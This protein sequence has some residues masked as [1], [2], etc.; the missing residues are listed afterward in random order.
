MRVRNIGGIAAVA[1]VLTACAGSSDAA[2]GGTTAAPPPSPVETVTF[3][4]TITDDD[5]QQVT[6]E[7]PP[8][9]IVTF[10]PSMTETL[11]A[12]GLGDRLVG[13]SGPY[14]D[15]PAAAR[16]VA[17]IGGAGEFGVDP[18][19]EK[20]VSLQPDLF[21][22]ISGGDQWKQELR[23]LS[24]P[25]VTLNATDLPD[26]LEDIRV[27][28]DVT[29]ATEAS[30]AL[31]SDMQ[32][33]ADAVTASVDAAGGSVSCFFEVYFPPLTSIGPDTFIYDLLERAGCDPTTAG[34]KADY[35][36]WSVE[37]LI[38]GQPDV[39]LA[40]PESAKSTDAVASRPGFDAI[41][42]VSSGAVV[43]VD[44]DLITRPGPRVIDGLEALEAGLHPSG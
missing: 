18:N 11:F 16:Q 23:D 36:L 32:E 43:L 40:T 5:G 2:G 31:A 39:Y 6:I 34:A 20:V 12:L 19:I 41:S 4:V 26:L 24:V 30:D 17:E 27:V 28:G 25:V 8:E 10:A 37:K 9:R 33:R 35:P 3:P 38:E 1:I 14:D 44:S 42:A 22:T 15:Y 29:G 7:A 13:V 21:L